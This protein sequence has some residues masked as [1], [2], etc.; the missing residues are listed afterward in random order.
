MADPCP[1]YSPGGFAHR[2]APL[3]GDQFYRHLMVRNDRMEDADRRDGAHE[4]ELWSIV[5]MAHFALRPATEWGR[6][7][8]IVIPMAKSASQVLGN[9]LEF[10][11]R[12][13]LVATNRPDRSFKTMV[14]VVVHGHFG[15]HDA[16]LNPIAR[17]IGR[18]TP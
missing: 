12:S 6:R 2:P 8:T 1:Q 5:R 14:D 17:G 13:A 18:Y 16:Y 3:L 9:F 7:H 4:Y 11:D 15:R 10:V